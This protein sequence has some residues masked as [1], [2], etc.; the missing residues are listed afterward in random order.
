MKRRIMSIKC[1][2]TAVAL[3]TLVHLHLPCGSRVSPLASWRLLHFRTQ[4]FLIRPT[5]LLKLSLV[6]VESSLITLE[7]SQSTAIPLLL[8][9]VI[10]SAC[11]IMA[12]AF[13]C[14]KRKSLSP[15]ILLLLFEGG[16]RVPEA[17]LNELTS[18]LAR[19]RPMARIRET[20]GT[21]SSRKDSLA[22][23]TNSGHSS[24][25]RVAVNCVGQ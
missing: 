21:V 4:T 8:D 23:L 17:M 2:C 10:P 22:C 24:R 16:I 7:I 1:P 5:V 6:R 9:N 18:D 14:A 12:D 13:Y 25:F 19:P 3:L 15:Y 20:L 11:N